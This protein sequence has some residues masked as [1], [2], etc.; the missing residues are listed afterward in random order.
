[1]LWG[2]CLKFW[3]LVAI[4]FNYF[5]KKINKKWGLGKMGIGTKSGTGR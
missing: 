2:F 4:F 5:F 3:G 1:M